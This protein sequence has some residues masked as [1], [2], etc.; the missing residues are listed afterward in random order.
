MLEIFKQD[1]E[2]LPSSTSFY[3]Y[4]KKSWEAFQEL[5]LQ[6]PLK[7]LKTLSPQNPSEVSQS[8]DLKQSIYPECN[9]SSLIFIDGAFAPSLSN[10]SAL[11]SSIV[12]LPLAL[13]E[14]TYPMFFKQRL[15]LLIEEDTNPLSLLNLALHKEGCFLYI[16]PKQLINTPIACTHLITK[17]PSESSYLF[18]RL[19]C[20]IG[21]E[22]QI[23]IIVSTHTLTDQ[24]LLSHMSL[25]FALEAGAG[26]HVTQLIADDVPH[27]ISESLRASLKKDSSFKVV[28]I[29]K[30]SVG[31]AYQDYRVSLL[32]SGASANLQGLS[33]L[34]PLKKSETQVS[35]EHIAP[36]TRS[37]QHFKGVLQTQSR[38][39]FK[40][41]IKVRK[42]AQKTEAYQLNNH[43]ILGPNAFADSDP[44][45]EIFAD[46]VKASH[47]ATIAQIDPQQLLYLK[48]RG[49][50]EALG[51][52][53]L[54]T[55]FC[56]EI[57]TQIPHLFLLKKLLKDPFFCE[58]PIS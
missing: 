43:L 35:I 47:G 28:S 39:R 8:P 37:M 11:P 38:S 15:N 32:E 17:N 48:T 57:T 33:L 42:E 51:K 23:Q 25:D 10:L 4:R 54:I 12:L 29:S 5:P 52:Q 55:G 19:H 27:L 2:K 34:Q 3:P 13:A 18:P 58:T 53:L 7:M 31:T 26:C 1:F 22:S 44:T 46:D 49:I 30:G 45:L 21:A 56:Q 20:S 41:K 36:H 50:D 24:A 40:G 6:E 16:P 14:T 9:G